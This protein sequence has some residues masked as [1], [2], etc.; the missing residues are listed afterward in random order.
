[1]QHNSGRALNFLLQ[2]ITNLLS[3]A[4]NYIIK[5]I[6]HVKIMFIW[7]QC[8]TVFQFEYLDIFITRFS[9]VIRS[10]YE[11]INKF[12][13]VFIFFLYKVLHFNDPLVCLSRI[14]TFFFKNNSKIHT[15]CVPMFTPNFE[16]MKSISNL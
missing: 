11:K 8:L 13:S 16:T 7:K 1:M 2:M 10:F 6:E 15:K 14:V 4:I 5:V 12:V 3:T 9:M